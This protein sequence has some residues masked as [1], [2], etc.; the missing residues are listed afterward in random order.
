MLTDGEEP[1]LFLIPY[2]A[3]ETSNSTFSGNDYGEGFKNPAE[4]RL[5]LTTR[6]LESLEPNRFEAM[7]DKLVGNLPELVRPPSMAS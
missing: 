5:N 6:N 4:W 7:V 3:R 1:E 2:K